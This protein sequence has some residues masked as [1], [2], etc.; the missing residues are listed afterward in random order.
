MDQQR[1]KQVPQPPQT[2]PLAGD[3]VRGLMSLERTVYIQTL[4]PYYV[5]PWLS[6]ILEEALFTTPLKLALLQPVAL[7]RDP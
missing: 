5:A 7:A 3:Q 1:T 4:A 6:L 2:V